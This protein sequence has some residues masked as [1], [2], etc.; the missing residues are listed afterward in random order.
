MGKCI[1]ACST[2][3]F[4]ITPTTITF[5][6]PT[7]TLLLLWASLYAVQ[8]S[9]TAP[10]SDSTCFFL[11]IL[12][13]SWKY[14]TEFPS[15]WQKAAYGHTDILFYCCSAFKICEL[16]AK[17]KALILNPNGTLKSPRKLPKY[18]SAWVLPSERFC[19]SLVQIHQCLFINKHFFFGCTVG[20]A[21]S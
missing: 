5:P 6:S 7:G 9:D 14:R 1:R 3:I 21:V 8:I 13:V 18:V 10:V 17:G 16:L 2:N 12:Y 11:T 19:L 15:W 20:H 4:S